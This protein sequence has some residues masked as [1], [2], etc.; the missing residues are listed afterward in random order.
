[1]EH[2]MSKNNSKNVPSQGTLETSAENVRQWI[3][4]NRSDLRHIAE[5]EIEFWHRV[6]TT[7]VTPTVWGMSGTEQ[8]NVVLVDISE[9]GDDGEWMGLVAFRADGKRELVSV[10]A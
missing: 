9:S 8:K 7:N 5:C 6:G 4:E 10:K 3:L 1:M 2:V